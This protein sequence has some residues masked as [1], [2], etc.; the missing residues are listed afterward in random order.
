MLKLTSLILTLIQNLLTI[1]NDFDSY[2][3]SFVIVILIHIV[4]D[5]LC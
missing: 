4:N 1:F 2:H 5:L 3:E